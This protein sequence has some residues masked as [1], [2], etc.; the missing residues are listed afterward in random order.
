MAISRKIHDSKYKTIPCMEF[1]QFHPIESD[2]LSFGFKDAAHNP[3]RPAT[4]LL[5]F[6]FVAVIVLTKFANDNV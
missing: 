5:A 3:L 4:P 2:K 1:F 6:V